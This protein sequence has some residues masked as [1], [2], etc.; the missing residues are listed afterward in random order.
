MIY[1]DRNFKSPLIFIIC[2][3]LLLS[4]CG[5]SPATASPAAS[6]PLISSS[7]ETATASAPLSGKTEEPTEYR[8]TSESPQRT[9]RDELLEMMID[10]PYD[11]DPD[12]MLPSDFGDFFT[13]EHPVTKTEKKL[14]EG[15]DYEMTMTVIEGAEPGP[16]MFIVAGVHGDETAAWH[17]GNLIE[18]ASVKAGKLYI[19]S[20]ANSNGAKNNTRYVTDKLDL[21]RSFPGSPY[22]NTAE[23]IADAILTEIKNA[24]PFFL[25]DLHEARIIQTNYDYLGSSLIFTDLEGIGDLFFDLVFATETGEICSE[26]FNYHAPAPKGSINHTV[27]TRLKVPSLTV[28]TFRGYPLERRIADQLDIV[29]YTMKFYNML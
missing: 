15:T 5:Q 3:A 19:I 23:K 10:P 2:M 7:A 18:K 14:M 17:A 21:N 28:E 1:F 9:S 13:T 29:Q 26:P 12:N 6:E 27:T 24:K 22:G 20:P 4:A 25:F 11:F 8:E 16:T